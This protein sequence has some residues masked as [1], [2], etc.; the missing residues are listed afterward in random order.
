MCNERAGRNARAHWQRRCADR[1][2]HEW[3]RRRR[4][5]VM[6]TTVDR[7]QSNRIELRKRTTCIGVVGRLVVVVVVQR[8]RVLAAN[9]R[10]RRHTIQQRSLTDASLSRKKNVFT[11][12]VRGYLRCRHFFEHDRRWQRATSVDQ[13]YSTTLNHKNKI[14]FRSTLFSCGRQI[15][16]RYFRSTAA[17]V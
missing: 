15:C 16:K 8:T 11:A 14:S 4:F 17:S 13:T 5:Y 9:N 6:T 1:R 3:R 2:R 10:R 7:N 12:C